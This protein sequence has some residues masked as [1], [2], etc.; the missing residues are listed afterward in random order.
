[1]HY[2]SQEGTYVVVED[3]AVLVD[4]VE[5]AGELVKGQH[6]AIDRVQLPL[7]THQVTVTPSGTGG[8][9][10]IRHDVFVVGVVVVYWMVRSVEECGREDE[11][12]E[13]EVGGEAAQT[14]VYIQG[15]RTA[16]RPD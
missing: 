15:E 2:T 14:D 8:L 6:R 5:Q 9:L 16:K 3:R 13:V 4:E 7:G 12:R 10:G 1:L 11:L